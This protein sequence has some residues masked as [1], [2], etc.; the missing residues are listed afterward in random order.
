MKDPLHHDVID[1]LGAAYEKMFERAVEGFRT[2]KEEESRSDAQVHRR[3][4]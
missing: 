3:C 1:A 4:R 2:V